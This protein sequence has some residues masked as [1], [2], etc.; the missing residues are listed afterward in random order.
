MI[1]MGIALFRRDPATLRMIDTWWGI[2]ENVTLAQ[3]VYDAKVAPARRKDLERTAR[4]IAAKISEERERGAGARRGEKG[5]KGKEEEGEGDASS[6]SERRRLLRSDEDEEREVKAT[7]TSNSAPKISSS[8]SSSSSSSV[9]SSRGRSSTR[10][11]NNVSYPY[12]PSGFT[13]AR[14]VTMAAKTLEGK[15]G[16]SHLVG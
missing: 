13:H 7:S 2:A 1:N 3:R 15:Y 6:A 16:K 8:S 4:R 5:E 12:P 10:G 11:A 14:L 9:R